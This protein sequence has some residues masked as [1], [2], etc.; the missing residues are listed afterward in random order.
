ME[1]TKTKLGISVGLLA[2]AAYFFAA[3]S[4]VPLVLVAGYILIREEDAWLRKSA[5]K[6]IAIVLF[7]MVV[8]AIIGVLMSPQSLLNDI[9]NFVNSLFTTAN[10]HISPRVFGWFNHSVSMLKHILNVVETLI[11]L[12]S[13]AMALKQKS[14]PF[15]PVEKII[16]KHM[17]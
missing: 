3:F 9:C 11:L 17:D 7:F 10:W 6:A 13:A 16:D 4:M 15:G 8:S 5:I 2:A 1:T 14:L 12:V